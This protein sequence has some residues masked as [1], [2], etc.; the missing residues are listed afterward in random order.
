MTVQ[1]EVEPPTPSLSPVSIAQTP[2]PTEEP[3]SVLVS[4]PL[5]PSE[6]ATPVV[7]ETAVVSTPAPHQTAA[8]SSVA[9]VEASIIVETLKSVSSVISETL[10][11][12]P[13]DAPAIAS[14]TEELQSSVV[15]AAAALV[16]PKEVVN[17]DPSLD[18]FFADL[19]LNEFPQK[20]NPIVDDA[21]PDHGVPESGEDEAEKL[22]LK[23]E[24][25]ARKRAEITTRHSKWETEL[26]TMVENKL[27]ELRKGLAAIRKAA[28]LEVKE[29]EL[30]RQH[31][32]HLDHEG[33]KFLRG[34]ETYF[35]QLLKEEKG[36]DDKSWS[37][38]LVINRIEEKFTE[39]T[40]QIEN[41]VNEW[42][43]GV[44]QREHDEVCRCSLCLLSVGNHISKR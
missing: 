18:D 11:D 13:T 24:E 42:S 30:M 26:E 7:D 16:T 41:S 15:S 19:G 23:T 32:E 5:P 33:E 25:T 4:D 28:A 2:P 36:D 3:S 35:Q 40:K 44:I 6:Q 20:L 14:L 39:K 21:P 29:S 9:H 34:A 43:R 37:W 8:E 31:V 38:S 17:G 1:T 22:R 12:I 10:Q 27:V